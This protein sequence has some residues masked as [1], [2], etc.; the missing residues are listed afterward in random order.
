VLYVESNDRPRPSF[1]VINGND[2][3]VSIEPRYAASNTAG[4]LPDE[5][6]IVEAD[7][8]SDLSAKV[9]FATAS[10][11]SSFLGYLDMVLKTE[12]TSHANVQGGA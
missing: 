7:R 11:C 5:S 1:V 6:S 12:S 3:V 4:P 10:S 9:T 2:R 8:L